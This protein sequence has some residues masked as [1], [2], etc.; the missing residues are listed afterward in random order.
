MT[1]RW[2][3][4]AALCLVATACG[5]GDGGADGAATAE[6]D[7]SAALRVAINYAPTSVDPHTVSSPTAGHAYVSLLYD[8]LTQMG[9]DLELRPM[10]ATEWTFGDGGRSV[11]FSLR[12]DVTFSDGAR[13]D[14]AAVTASLDRAMTVAGST[15]KGNL[16]MISAVEVVDPV[17]VRITTNRPAAD[18][19]YVLSGVEGSVISPAALDKPDLD[20]TAVG[21][22]PYTLGRLAVDDSVVLERREGYWDPQAQQAARIE[23]TGVPN[24]SARMNGLRSGQ[25]DMMMT[26]AGQFDQVSEL[27]DPYVT[28]SYP[29]A[30][31]YAVYLNT[32]RPNIDK[33]KVRQ[34]L[35]YAIDREG[36]SRALLD[37]RCTPS[38]QPLP[39]VYP[40]HLDPPPVE[41]AHDPE[42]ARQLL[43]EAGVPDGFGMTILVPAGISLYEQLAAAVQAQLAEVG[44]AAELTAQTGTQ[45]FGSW[46]DGGFDGL[47]NARTTRPTA[48]MTLQASYLTPSRFPGPTPPGFAEAVSSA[49]DPTLDEAAYEAA[50][51]KAST[52]GAESALDVF[53]CSVPAMWTSTDRVRGGDMMGLSYFSAFGDLRYV[54]I[55]GEG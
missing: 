19:P 20:V 40:G 17:T 4:A 49:Y 51:T 31:T 45:I 16:A 41:Y 34:A 52:I 55:A 23:L 2:A 43:A 48:A 11:T 27:G 50:V 7:R 5:S 14:A 42:R 28:H 30:T 35:N 10:L 54:G 24:D 8:R 37:G 3:V 44:I 1:K 46:G 36:I 29:P 6:V 53:L 47:V 22:G 21:S 32:A 9:P 15:A 26:T 39:S 33:V 13:V 38:A 18:L 12:D 25:F